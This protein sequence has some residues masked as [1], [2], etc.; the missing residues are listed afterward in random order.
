MSNRFNFYDVYAYLIPGAALL[1]LLFAPLLDLVSVDV[2][3]AV[4]G[5]VG[6]YVVGF[7]LQNSARRAL[8]SKCA[9]AGEGRVLPSTA[10]AYGRFARRFAEEVLLGFVSLSDETCEER[11]EE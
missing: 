3:G 1:V 5:V 2:E 6:A 10:V 4:V 9:R 8:P 7:V 11:A